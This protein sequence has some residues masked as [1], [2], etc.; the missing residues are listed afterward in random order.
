MTILYSL[1]PSVKVF[2]TTWPHVL[3]AAGSEGKAKEGTQLAV[4]D[5]E[6]TGGWPWQEAGERAGTQ[7]EQEF[8]RESDHANVSPSPESL[9][10]LGG[11]GWGDR[12]PSK[13]GVGTGAI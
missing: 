4:G 7:P 2:H 6:G 9:E 10:V 11:G 13:F 12:H 8:I 1:R 3:G 5:S